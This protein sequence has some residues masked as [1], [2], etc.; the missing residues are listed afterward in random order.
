MCTLEQGF[1]TWGTR[2]PRGTREADRGDASLSGLSPLWSKTLCVW[3]WFTL[4]GTQLLYFKIKGDNEGKRLGT[5]GLRP[6]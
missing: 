2:P 6:K 1:P 5:P 3:I 4:G